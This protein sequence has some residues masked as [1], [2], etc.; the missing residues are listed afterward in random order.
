MHRRPGQAFW[1]VTFLLVGSASPCVASLQEDQGNFFGQVFD[2]SGMAVEG[3]TLYLAP[4][5]GGCGDPA[6]PVH[7]PGGKGADPAG[8]ADVIIVTTDLRGGFE[9]R[10]PPGRYR[11][12]ALK[13]GYELL[14]SEIGIFTRAF[15]DLR[16]RPTATAARVR[17]R[18]DDPGLNW[19]LKQRRPDPLRDLQPAVAGAPEGATARPEGPVAG[20]LQA[21]DGEM[22][23]SMSGGGPFADPPGAGGTAGQTASLAVAGGIGAAG[24]WRLTGGFA[25]SATGLPGAA[26]SRRELRSGSL[27]VA[28]DYR[29]E[30]GD[31]IEGEIHYGEALAE[32]LVDGTGTVVAGQSRRAASIRSR[33]ERPLAGAGAIYVDGSYQGAGIG[34]HD[35]AGAADPARAALLP[36]GHDTWRAGAGYARDLGDHAVDFGF[37][38]SVRQGETGTQEFAVA[39]GAPGEARLERS[40]VALFGADDWRL[41]ERYTLNYGLSYWSDRDTGTGWLLPTIGFVRDPGFEGGWRVRS[42]LVFRLDD[43]LSG[44]AD[45]GRPTAP[46]VG[47]VIGFEQEPAAGTRIAATVAMVPFHDDLIA[48]PGGPGVTQ[49]AA[50]APVLSDGEAR[51]SEVGVEV[52]HVFGPFRGSLSGAVGRVVGRLSPVVDELPLQAIDEGEVRYWVTRLRG[53]YAPTETIVLVDVRRVVGSSAGAVGADPEA[54]DYRRVDLVLQQPLPWMS[55]AA[56]WRLQ[57]A[58]RGLLSGS[59]DL[60]PGGLTAGNVSRLSG[61]VSVMF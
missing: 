41:A 9:G 32:S 43:P 46:R 18:E 1:F 7:D 28:M 19:I 50:P 60:A 47:G 13:P 61:G 51:R 25:E 27:A 4:A 26:A 3:A 44:P 55:R 5:V 21:I 17:H 35:A 36:P 58:Y 23:W 11:I 16:L 22:S 45:A 15:H 2:T 59:S 53:V 56:R 33:W 40:E 12:A 24:R 39:A 10:V 20:L 34:W 8:C 29:L 37:R 49:S 48:V 54:H 52:D 6:T 30:G 57:M 42:L 31:R 14:L 38:A